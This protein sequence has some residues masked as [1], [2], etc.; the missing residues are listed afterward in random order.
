M[1]V[2][3]GIPSIFAVAALIAPA[4]LAAPPAA[5]QDYRSVTAKAI[6]AAVSGMSEAKADPESGQAGA[7][8]RASSE[9]ASRQEVTPPRTNA[10]QITPPDAPA[11]P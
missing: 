6:S 4:L 3:K 9:Q 10:G 5:A 7:A 11:Q 8:N 2:F 1:Q